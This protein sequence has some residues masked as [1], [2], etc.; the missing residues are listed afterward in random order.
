MKLMDKFVKKY[1]KIV[2]YADH[3]AK[4]FY[5]D[6][7][8]F[9]LSNNMRWHLYSKIRYFNNSEFLIKGF[10][11]EYFGILRKWGNPLSNEKLRNEK[12]GYENDIQNEKNT[13]K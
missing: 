11:L 1:K 4:E 5:K 10:S 7:F 8:N 3:M 13:L 9:K 2:L 12:I 6:K